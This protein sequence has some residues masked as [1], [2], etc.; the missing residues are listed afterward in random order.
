MIL[1]TLPFTF[2]KDLLTY[3]QSVHY[4]IVLTQSHWLINHYALALQFR[5]INMK[6]YLIPPLKALFIMHY[7]Y[8]VNVPLLI[9]YTP[10]DIISWL[11]T[12]SSF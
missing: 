3:P 12:Y 9:V 11:D 8:N 7:C 4:L 1:K 5:I 2:K 6:S 10:I